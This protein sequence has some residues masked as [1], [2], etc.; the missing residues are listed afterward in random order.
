MI[1]NS[2]KVASRD[3]LQI[4]HVNLEKSEWSG[5]GFLRIHEFNLALWGK[6]GWRLLSNEDS[7]V[8]KIFKARYYPGSNFLSASFGSNSSYVWR[9]NWGAKHIV[10][11]SS[12]CKIGKGK[13]ID[14]W[15]DPWLPFSNY[16]FKIST[17]HLEDLENTKV[18]NLLRT[19]CLEWDIDLISYLFNGRDRNLILKIPLSVSSVE[20]VWM[21]AGDNKGK[22]TVSESCSHAIAK[23]IDSQFFVV[24]WEDHPRPFIC[25]LLH[26]DLNA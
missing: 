7:L 19:D 23:E 20:D 3:Y 24:I 16:D 9:S 14:V 13:K 26:L 25:N 18:N 12:V 15:K 10:S 6:K 4:N 1:Q 22:Y 2:T 21:W 8:A 11:K 5:L 17:A